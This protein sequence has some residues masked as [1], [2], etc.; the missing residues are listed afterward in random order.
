MGAPGVDGGS[1]RRRVG[2]VVYISAHAH[3][4]TCNFCTVTGCFFVCVSVCPEFLL[5]QFFPILCVFFFKIDVWII[6]SSIL[7]W[8]G[9]TIVVG[10]GAYFNI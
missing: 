5:A 3:M 6:F 10:G 1:A 9:G 8:G 7:H 2:G 4:G